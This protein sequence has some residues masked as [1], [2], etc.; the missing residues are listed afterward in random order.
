MDKLSPE[1]RRLN[2]QHIQNKNTKP[3][4]KIRKLIYSKGYRYRIHVKEL[5]GKPDIV[6]LGRKKVIFINGCFWHKHNCKQFYLPKTNRNFW[7]SKINLN[8]TRDKKNYSALQSL[9][10]DILII[11]ECEITEKNLNILTQR[12]IDFLE[13]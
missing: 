12:I 13:S 9:G 7:S 1:K 10:W 4:L 8:F 6:F 5:P 2:M 11:W 3:E